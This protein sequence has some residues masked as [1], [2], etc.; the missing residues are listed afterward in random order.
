MVLAILI[1][2]PLLGVAA[3]EFSSRHLQNWISRGILLCMVCCLVLLT[4]GILHG[5][6]FEWAWP[7]DRSSRSLFEFSWHVSRSGIPLL[8]FILLAGGTAF[9]LETGSR[10]NRIPGLVAAAMLV[11]VANDVTSLLTGGFLTALIMW[12]MIPAGT[13]EP[14]Q[15]SAERRFLSWQLT[16]WMCLM[17]SFA[18]LAGALSL[19]RSA[20]RAA[21]SE[22]GFLLTA[23][24]GRIPRVV[25]Q[26]PAALEM[27]E[28]IRGWLLIPAIT[29]VL[30]LS[31]TFPFHAS[32]GR[33]KD[34][35]DA[36]EHLLFHSIILRLGIYILLTSILPIYSQAPQLVMLGIAIPALAGMFLI[37]AELQ[38]L[39]LDEFDWRTRPLQW[40][41][42]LGLLLVA[43]NVLRPELALWTGII[44][45]GV[46]SAVW[47]L[48]TSPETKSPLVQLFA[49]LAMCGV[50]G[51]AATGSLLS[52]TLNW[53]KTGTP[54]DVLVWLG[55]WGAV[56]AMS[57]RLIPALVKAMARSVNE[58]VARHTSLT[59]SWLLLW[60][61]LSMTTL[62]TKFDHRPD[63]DA[64]PPDQSLSE[65]AP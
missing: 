6:T 12:L 16:G 58:P 41:S 64:P 28:Q 38:S 9:V 61:T 21:P 57:L 25:E 51:L 23:D 31:G 36:V 43:L 1:L 65:V 26:H 27:W 54:F 59:W 40:L 60:V 3:G 47:V 19:L 7:E 46:L 20:P 17:L 32:A 53:P 24:L 44:L 37:A 33:L 49:G 5:Q 29:G 4:R 50:P 45:P 10:R 39:E 42:H 55:L 15:E 48:A 18:A 13:S 2:L 30:I 22:T 14:A 62:T 52:V 56:F 11:A 34:R 8:W 63:S 35:G